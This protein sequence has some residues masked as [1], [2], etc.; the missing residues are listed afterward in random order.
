MLGTK[1]SS[2]VSYIGLATSRKT[3]V[4]YAEN[5]WALTIDRIGGW[6][7]RA[8][9]SSSF[10]RFSTLD[11]CLVAHIYPIF[12]LFVPNPLHLRTKFARRYNPHSKSYSDSM[13]N[14]GKVYEESIIRSDPIFLGLNLIICSKSE[15]IEEG[16]KPFF[17][18]QR[19]GLN[20]N[21]CSPYRAPD[22]LKRDGQRFLNLS[23]SG[24][25]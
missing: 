22:G 5:Y 18:R 10:E 17:F 7:G 14:I 24:P 20:L 11:I 12:F 23:E 16:P 9:E 19:K 15:L 25:A 6:R 8:L 3:Q 21:I 2:S 4:G 13:K 1:V